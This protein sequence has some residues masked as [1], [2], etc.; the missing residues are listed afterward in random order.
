MSRCRR[1]ASVEERTSQPDSNVDLCRTGPVVEDQ[2]SGDNLRGVTSQFKGLARPGRGGRPPNGKAG[3]GVGVGAV[4][5][6]K[7]AAS[8]GERTWRPR[9]D[10]Q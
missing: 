5:V 10:V 9:R 8:V 3:A 7:C 6:R 1:S 2:R 4:A